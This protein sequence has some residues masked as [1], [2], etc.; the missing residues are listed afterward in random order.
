M[1]NVFGPWEISRTFHPSIFQLVFSKGEKLY[2]VRI[3]SKHFS[4]FTW[5]FIFRTH[6]EQIRKRFELEKIENRIKLIE[7]I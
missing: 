3:R 6:L 2:L 4:R 1:E 5:Q 7:L